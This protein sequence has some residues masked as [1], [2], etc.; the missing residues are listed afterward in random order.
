MDRLCPGCRFRHSARLADH[1]LAFTLPDD[2]WQG[3]V[4]DVLPAP[5]HQVWGALYGI[6]PDHLASLDAYEGY[7]PAGEPA[8]NAYARRTL[9]VTGPDGRAVP[10]VWCY[11]V[12]EPRGHVAPSDLYRQALLQGACERQL[13]AA[14]LDVMRAAFDGW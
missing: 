2:E 8:Q 10:G 7:D 3:G 5:G 11:F 6:T 14:Y 13:P 12:R 9:E 4:A 1:R